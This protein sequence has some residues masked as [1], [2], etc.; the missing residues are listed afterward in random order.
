MISYGAGLNSESW[1]LH[2]VYIYADSMQAEAIER[3]TSRSGTAAKQKSDGGRQRQT[4][5]C[6]WC[7]HIEACG[8]DG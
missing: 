1:S 8:A 5:E 2:I 3:A 7:V 4:Y 6:N